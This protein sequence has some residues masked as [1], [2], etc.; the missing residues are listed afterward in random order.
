MFCR[1]SASQFA[2]LLENISEKRAREVSRRIRD[3]FDQKKT[4]SRI[5]VVYHA[6]PVESSLFIDPFEKMTK[7]EEEK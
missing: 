5:F 7:K 1:A 4:E 6:V 3:H 2:V